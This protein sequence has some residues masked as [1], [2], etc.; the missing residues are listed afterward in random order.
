[1]EI[2]NNELTRVKYEKYSMK[3]KD[4]NFMLLLYYL[5]YFIFSKYMDYY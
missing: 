1:M 4:Q 2:Q 5:Y 3:S